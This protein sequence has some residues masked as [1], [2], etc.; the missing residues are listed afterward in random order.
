MIHYCCL[1]CRLCISQTSPTNKLIENKKIFESNSFFVI[2]TLGQFIPGWLMIVSKAHTLCSIRHSKMELIELNHIIK[3]TSEIVENNF[4]RTIIFEHGNLNSSNYD[5]GCCVNHT[6]I[7]VC[8]YNNVEEI[9][10]NINYPFVGDMS[11]IDFSQKDKPDNGYIFINTNN[12][13]GTYKFYK[14]DEDIETQ[15]LRKLIAKSLN[16]DMYWDWAAFPFYDNIRK[17][18]QKINGTDSYE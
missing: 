14:I 16:K 8:P 18:F 7:H 5:L 17:T 6:H 11:I 13:E 3:K 15:Y 2:P 4:G 9:L 12:D 1:M 10:S